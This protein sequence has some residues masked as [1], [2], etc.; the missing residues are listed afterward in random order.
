[1][2]T[3]PSLEI[4]PASA[5]LIL[6]LRTR[7]R[8]E[9][10]AQIVHDS[11]HRRDGWA[12][13]WLLIV[14]GMSAGFGSVAIAGPWKDK[15]TAFE[16]YVLPEHRRRAFELFELFLKTSAARFFEAQTNEMLLTVMV[17]TYGT[18]I[19]SEKIVFADGQT[20]AH[21]AV[22]VSLRCATP[23]EEILEALEQ[24]QGG[25]EWVLE[26]DGVEIGR[27]GILFHYNRPYGDIYMD[28]SEAQRRRGW[29]RYLV[30]ELKREC[31]ELGAVPCARCSPANV[32]SRKTLQ[33]AGFVPVAHII[34][35]SLKEVRGGADSEV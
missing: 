14:D 3:A 21:E 5:E 22:G 16:F 20:T 10:N 19:A 2:S 33:A 35:G 11:I 31:Y 15:P 24:R 23:R 13:S 12:L 1:M 26:Q 18:D 27:G 9:V 34:Y 8:Q 4:Q 30:Q 7:H 32:A 17:H 25:G 6:P 28:V 29:G